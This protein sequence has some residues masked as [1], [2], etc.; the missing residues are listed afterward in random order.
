[1]RSIVIIILAGGLVLITSTGWFLTQRKASSPVIPKQGPSL[2]VK[3]NVVPLPTEED[4]IRTFFNLI[5]EKRIPEAIAMMSQKNTTD[6]AAGVAWGIH[7]NAIKSVKVR[8]I[9]ASTSENWGADRHTYKVALDV[10]VSPETASAP[11]PYYGWGDNPNFRWVTLV[12]EG[13]LWKI[14]ELATGP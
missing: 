10:S 1:M 12:K 14:D 5:N 11:V 8:T 7:F 2:E 4:I 6:E 9:E 3:Q 13:N